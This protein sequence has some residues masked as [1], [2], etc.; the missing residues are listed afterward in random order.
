MEELGGVVYLVREEP[1]EA[2]ETT[3]D[4]N[5]REPLVALWVAT[6]SH[7]PVPFTMCHGSEQQYVVRVGRQIMSKRDA[8]TSTEVLGHTRKDK[9]PVPLG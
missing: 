1:T 8:S 7:I 9:K 2:R 5:N 6:I 4:N 3:L